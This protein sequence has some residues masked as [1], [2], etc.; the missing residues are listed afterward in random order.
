MGEKQQAL[1]LSALLLCGAAPP[2][3][4][5]SSCSGCHAPAS[6][7]TGIPAITGQRA[8][9]LVAVLESFRN[10]TRTATVMNRIVK[11]FT[12]DQ[13]QAIAAWWAAQP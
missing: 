11:G 13:V 6:V 12:P 1:V 7:A 4:G 5:A 9:H 8:D 3:P 10:G 2:P